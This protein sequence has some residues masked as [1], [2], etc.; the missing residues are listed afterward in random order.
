MLALGT[1]IHHKYRKYDRFM[2]DLRIGV[3]KQGND[4]K[5]I[6]VNCKL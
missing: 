5:V 3:E 6:F 1:V 4:N 2:A